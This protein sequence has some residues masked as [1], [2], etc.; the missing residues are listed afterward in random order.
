MKIHLPILPFILRWG[1]AFGFLMMLH[2][3][4]KCQIVVDYGKS[5][6][7][8]TKGLNGGTIEPGD[9]LEM[10]STFVVRCSGTCTY[11]DSCG[12]FDTVKTGMNYIPN[13]LAVLTNEGK[14][15][16]SFTDTWGDDCGYIVGNNIRINLGYNNAD[17]P[18]DAFRRGRLKS[19]HKPSFYGST[20]IMVASYKVVVTAALG[21]HI[22]TGG[23]SITYKQSTGGSIQSVNFPYNQAM[24]FTNYGICSNTVGAN[25]LGTEFNGSFGSG[26]NRNRTASANVP[27]NY[28]YNIFTTGGPQDYY[29]G[30][31]NNTSTQNYSTLNTWPKPDNSSPSHRVFSVWDIIGDHTGAASPLLGNPAAD[32]V[33]NNNAGYML[34]VN[35]SYRIDSAFTHTVSGLCPNT[36]YELSAWFRNICSKCGCDSNG[37]GASTSGYIPTA[38]GDS[39]G[40]YPNLTI[41]VDGIDYYSTGNMKYTGQWIKKGFTYLTGP[42]QTSLRMTIRNN[43]PGGGGNDWALD[44]ITL[45]TCTPTLLLVPSGGLN[46]CE[47]NQVDMFTTVSCFTP[48]YIYWIWERSTDGGSTWTSTGVNGTG[49][50]VWVNNTWKYTATF[51]SFIADASYDNNMFR[52]RVASSPANLN[53]N[54]CSFSASNTIS[55]LVNNCFTTLNTKIF[56]FE[57]GLN[58]GFRKLKWITENEENGVSFQ[59]QKSEENGPFKTIASFMGEA[60]E[61]LGSMYQFTEPEKNDRAANYRVLVLQ[62]HRAMAS[63]VV[64][65]QVNLKPGVRITNN[66]VKNQLGIE[67]ISEGQAN[68]AFALLDIYGR[69]LFQRTTLLN[70]G[71]QWVNLPMGNR[72]APGTYYL[73]IKMGNLQVNEKILKIN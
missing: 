38:V 56:S 19:T 28:T 14:I 20:C 30:I 47:G 13:S 48:N 33:T 66:P 73:N 42:T 23:G 12:Y 35:A 7:N 4:T 29:Y 37:R 3:T 70:D 1:Y 63:K 64:N 16:K 57:G 8:I 21:T 36:Y 55:V 44:D 46:I 60:P 6:V 68:A 26:K 24:I 45:A 59:L 43:A 25:A 10:R 51:P 49:N 50:P 54:G 41:R 62:N 61:G 2:V 27:A 40:V 67:I 52:I 69:T 17:A 39:S 18:A 5:Y 65:F 31:P 9:T 72:L 71:M 11:I 58:N 32:T 53:N 34:V 15:Y 22:N